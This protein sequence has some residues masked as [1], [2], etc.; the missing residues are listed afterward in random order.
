MG[1][2][3]VAVL[4][5][6]ENPLTECTLEDTVKPCGIGSYSIVVKRHLIGCHGQGFIEPV[7][8]RVIDRG[9]PGSIGTEDD[10][11]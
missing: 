6:L 8:I 2:L 5:F 10:S 9:L 7:N 1:Y 11:F 4:N 3:R